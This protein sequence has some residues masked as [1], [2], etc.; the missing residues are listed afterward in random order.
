MNGP[1]NSALPGSEAAQSVA[2]PADVV[3]AISDALADALVTE[4]LAELLGK[5][6]VS[7]PM[8]GSPPGMDSNSD[9]G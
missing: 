6:D 2:L 3:D 5:S 1:R 4:I 7:E 8:V 9:A